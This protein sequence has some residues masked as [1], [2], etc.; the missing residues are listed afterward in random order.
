VQKDKII[1]QED[2]EGKET[3]PFSW[4]LIILLHENN[5]EKLR[6]RTKEECGIRCLCN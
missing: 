2:E 5:T 6:T 3:L 4:F 1:I